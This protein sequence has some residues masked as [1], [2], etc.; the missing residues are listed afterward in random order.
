MK[1]TLLL[2]T[3]TGCSQMVQPSDAGVKDATADVKA[4]VVQ[5]SQGEKVYLSYCSVCHGKDGK[6]NGGLSANFV[7]DKSR[8]AKSDKELFD[9]IWNGMG[10][11]PAWSSALSKEQVTQVIGY[12]RAAFGNK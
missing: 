9:S 11:M 4:P 10:G 6:G 2:L 5:M 7:D 3:L 12:L 1:K 8:L